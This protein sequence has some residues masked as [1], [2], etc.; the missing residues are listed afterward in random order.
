MRLRDR[1]YVQPPRQRSGNGC[2]WLV[3]WSIVILVA[4]GYLLVQVRLNDGVQL[5]RDARTPTPA[6]TPTPTRSVDSLIRAAEEAAARGDYRAAIDAYDR[7]SRRRPNDPDLHRRA[8]RLMVF[9]GQPEKAEQRIRR[10]LEIDPN[11]LPSRAVLCMA[12][13]W[14]KR[15]AE[16]VA[17]CQAVVAADPNYATGH[18]YLAEA[19]ADSG[20]FNAAR[21]AAQRAVDLEPNNPDA[22]RNLGYVYD[23]FGRYDI[24]RY[25][26][27]RALEREPN[28]PHVLSAIGRIFYVTGRT[29]DAIRTFQRIIEIDPQHA[30]AYQQLGMVYRF[31]GERQKA[32]EALDKAIELEPTRLRALTERALLNFQVRNYFGAVEDYT[33]A[34]T[35][36]QQSGTSL[37]AIDYLYYGFAYR[38]IQECDNARAMWAKSLELAPGDQE[39]RANVEAGLAACSGR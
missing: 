31:I 33:R 17:E 24:A 12:L 6:L 2:A 11:H 21:S 34:L 5:G 4:G 1:R 16:A 25:H 14:Q 32:R 35:L 36:T 9:I 18:A 38:W 8:A 37:S 19:L 39:I 29:A 7:A 13:D 26:Y 20:D 23:V 3:L 15:I 10:A 28:M 22:L 27:E 30:E